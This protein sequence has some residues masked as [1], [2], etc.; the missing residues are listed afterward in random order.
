MDVQL[1][2][3]CS[4]P[5]EIISTEVLIDLAAIYLQHFGFTTQFIN[6][7]ILGGINLTTCIN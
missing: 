4:L 2:D 1:M 3:F 6:S 7:G 5:L